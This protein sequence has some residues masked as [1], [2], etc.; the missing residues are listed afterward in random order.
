MSAVG[1]ALLRFILAGF[2]IAHWWFKVG[3]RGM[4]ATEA[5]FLPAGPAGLAR[6]VRYQ[7]RGRDCCL[8]DSRNL[9]ALAMPDQPADPF[10]FDVDISQEWA[11]FLGRWSRASGF[12]GLCANRS[13]LS[14]P[15]RFSGPTS[16]V[17]T[18]P[19]IVRY[20]ALTAGRRSKCE[21]RSHLSSL[22]GRRKGLSLAH[23]G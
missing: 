14:R 19:N 7:L 13:G 8:P 5:F 4:P 22:R 15:R 17:A 9:C 23:L 11:L 18:A 20:P 21:A 6:V 1:A 3:Y 10:C 2:W 16:A 12:V